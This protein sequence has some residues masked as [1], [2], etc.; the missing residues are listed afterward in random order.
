V[1]AGTPCLEA[2]GLVLASRGEVVQRGLDF[3][4]GEGTIF[5]ITGDGGSGKSFLLRHLLGLG[6]PAE[7]DVL[8]DGESLWEGSGAARDRLRRRSGVLFQGAGLLSEATLLENVALK[9]RLNT[10]LSRRD[11]DEVAALKL[12]IMGAGG[13]ERRYPS[14]VSES[15][16]ARAALARATALDPELLFFDEPAARLDPLSSRRVDEIIL[17]LHELTGATIVLATYDLQSLLALADDAVFLDSEKRTMIA[18]G[19]PSDLRDHCPDPKVRA[20]L[21]GG[22]P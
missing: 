11:A 8:H 12:A 6:R 22:R 9:L 17:E 13:H 1:G 7:G 3:E 21:G 4:V 15:L 14:E 10:P 5:A 2:R 19:R 18:R 16:R 20:F